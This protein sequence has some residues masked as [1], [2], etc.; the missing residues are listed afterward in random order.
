MNTFEPTMTEEFIRVGK[1]EADTMIDRVRDLVYD[2]YKSSGLH[3]DICI[4]GYIT[5]ASLRGSIQAKCGH[6]MVTDVR[7]QA[8]GGG[9][10]SFEGVMYYPSL[11][12]REGF[13]FANTNT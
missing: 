3:P 4:A 1:S 2:S 9:S 10:F 7:V 6:W 5:Y 11:T 13:M 12:Q 8:R